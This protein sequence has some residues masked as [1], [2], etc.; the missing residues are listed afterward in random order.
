MVIV[1]ERLTIHTHDNK[2][3]NDKY[4]KNSAHWPFSPQKGDH[5]EALYFLLSP[6]YKGYP[7]IDLSI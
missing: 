6:T 3:L 4:P 5:Q 2:F 7:L 1:D